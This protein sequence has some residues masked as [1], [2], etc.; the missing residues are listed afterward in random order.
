MVKSSHR[1]DQRR[2]VS[3][4]RKL[5]REVSALSFAPPVAYCYNPLDYAWRAHREYL[6]RYGGAPKEIIFLGM[7]PGPF[8]MVQTGIPFGDVRYVRDWLGL[9][10][11][12]GRPDPEHPRRPVLGLSCP[13]QEVSGR[14]VWGWAE[15]RF[16]TPARFFR[17]CFVWNYCPLCFIEESGKNRTPDKLPKQECAAL[18]AACDAALS[19]VVQI[20]QPDIVFGLGAFAAQ[21]AGQAL[22]CC[23]VKVYRLPHPSPANP[24]A[25][26]WAKAVDAAL[27]RLGVSL[28]RAHCC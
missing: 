16:K 4:A 10:G 22:S 3:V 7:N 28:P 20:L 5:G 19:A 8:G 18:F 24:A 11:A 1:T 14:R 25:H 26:Q 2:L 21:R 9:R 13:R 6:L 12:S 27:K 17:Q 23:P 15:R